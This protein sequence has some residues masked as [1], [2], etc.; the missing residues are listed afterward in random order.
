M[1]FIFNFAV[2]KMS[3]IFGTACYLFAL[4]RVWINSTYFTCMVCLCSEDAVLVVVQLN[5]GVPNTQ[6]LMLSA[7]LQVMK[8]E[9][10]LGGDLVQN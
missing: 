10:L 1:G 5:P 2:N 4:A 3:C 7:F 6:N 8:V 9:C